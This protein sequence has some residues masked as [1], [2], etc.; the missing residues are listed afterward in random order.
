M[1]GGKAV[2]VGDALQVVS[3]VAASPP[4]QVWMRPISTLAEQFGRKFSCIVDWVA[5]AAKDGDR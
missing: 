4:P 5:A 3:E 1:A 2:K